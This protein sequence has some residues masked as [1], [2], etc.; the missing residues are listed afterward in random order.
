MLSLWFS[1]TKPVMVRGW[2][3]AAS[4]PR[5]QP[6]IGGGRGWG[7]CERRVFWLGFQGTQPSGCLGSSLQT[8]VICHLT[9]PS[10]FKNYS[11]AGAA[12]GAL[13]AC[14]KL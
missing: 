3:E 14:R 13:F 12:G 10:C 7:S 2:R 6:I 9:S 8:M 5:E 4:S 11:G 1:T